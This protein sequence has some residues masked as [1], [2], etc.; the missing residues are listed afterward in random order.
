MYCEISNKP[1]ICPACVFPSP[2]PLFTHSGLGKG[3]FC[4]LGLQNTIKMS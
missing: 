3:L 1:H 2:A 4:S